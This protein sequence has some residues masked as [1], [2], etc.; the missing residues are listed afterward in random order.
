MNEPVKMYEE[1][2]ENPQEKLPVL[3]LIEE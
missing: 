1:Q 3:L 2:K